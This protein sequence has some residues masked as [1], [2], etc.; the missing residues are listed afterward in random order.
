[1]WAEINT[2]AWLD[3]DLEV[4]LRDSSES[5]YNYVCD[6]CG[7]EF[8]NPIQDELDDDLCP[9]CKVTLNL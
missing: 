5:N 1:M 4:Y 9:E 2:D 8:D 7:H 3:H 6:N